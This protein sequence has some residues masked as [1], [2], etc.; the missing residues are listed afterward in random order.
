[1]QVIR[2]SALVL[3][4]GLSAAGAMAGEIANSNINANNANS[5]ASGFLSSANQG[6]GVADGASAS[7]TNSNITAGNANNR[8]SGFLSSATQN[9]GVA[10]QNGR[11]E[12]SNVNAQNARN[13]ASGF[14]SYGDAEGRLR[15]GQRPRHELER[16]APTTSATRLAASSP[17]Q[18]RRSAAPP[19]TACCA[20]ATSS[21]RTRTTR[22]RASSARARS[23][24]AWRV[25][26]PPVLQ[27]HRHGRKP[28][29]CFLSE[30][31]CPV[32]QAMKPTMLEALAVA[33][34]LAAVSHARAGEETFEIDNRFR[35]KIAKEKIRQGGAAAP[36]RRSPSA[37]ASARTMP[38][39]AART[40]ATSTPTAVAAPHRA[41]CSSSR[42]T[43][44]T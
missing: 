37:T 9:I 35:A 10:T 1:M 43:R 16:F 14:L 29:R 25:K 40:S 30:V 8:A 41:R 36:P 2:K 7:I 39:A 21:R 18:L 44:S 13:T 26:H 23:A 5:T 28:W 27:V 15:R 24:S 17:A 3:A 33:V 32:E 34:L 22:R 12:N 4:L 6:I 31:H 20:T 19:T 42:R 38:N 11:I